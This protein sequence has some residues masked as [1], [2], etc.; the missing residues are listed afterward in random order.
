MKQRHFMHV[1]ST[2][3]DAGGFK[4]Q[5]SGSVTFETD[6]DPALFVSTVAF[7]EPTKNMCVFLLITYPIL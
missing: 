3:K 7:K 2:I 6:P 1:L 5:C 4:N